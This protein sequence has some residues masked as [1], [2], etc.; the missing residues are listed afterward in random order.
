MDVQAARRIR[1][2][3]LQTVYEHH[4]NPLWDRQKLREQFPVEKVRPASH[5][6]VSNVN[7][8][9]RV[10]LDQSITLSEVIDNEF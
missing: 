4:T 9:N 7:H 1:N 10:I 2:P 3:F 6:L 5:R 8:H